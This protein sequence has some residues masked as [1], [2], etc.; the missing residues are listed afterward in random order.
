MSALY[1]VQNNQ[2]TLKQHP[3]QLQA[4]DSKKRIV[5]IL[6]GT[7]G[8][9]T[10][11]LPWWLWREI[12][13]T[14]DPAGNNDY[15]AITASYDL[16]KLKFLPA[17]REV[18]ENIF[19]IG[20]YWSGDR[21][22]ELR[23]PATGEFW[24]K[25]ADDPMWGRIILRSAESGG[26][27]ESATARGAIFDEAGQDSATVD[28]YWAIRR[29]LSLHQGRLCLG[30]TLYNL[31]W[32]KSEIYDPW[33]KMKRQH[34]EIDVIQFESI[35]NPSFPKAEYE[36]AKASLP[37][38]KFDMMY[39]GVY[40]RPAG[41]IYDVFDRSLHT[42][43]PFAIPSEWQ[44]YLGL[45][46]GGVNTA[47]VFLAEEPTSKKLYVY[48]TY[49]EGS[50]T[51]KEHAIELLRGEPMIPFAVGGSP[52]E[53]QWRREFA[54]GGLAVRS[55]DVKEVEIGIDRVYGAFKRG[56][57][58]IFDNLTDLLGELNSYSRDVDAAGNVL[59]R[60]SN[61]SSYH[62]LDALRYIVG[63]LKRGA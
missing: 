37:R 55:P 6:A 43:P 46:F 59:E 62:L 45:D 13:Q 16:F 20:K 44:R 8:G 3:G 14:A 58:V 56:E 61:K 21:I 18:F 38:W 60:I 33:E 12:Q 42:C 50:R 11:W 2:L 47:A 7:Q 5:A 57:I 40:S 9:K 48:R 10:S 53:G 28:T 22:I 17:I 32:L 1:T 4:W 51:G 39:R 41:Q 36:A 19:G 26:G 31:G 52:S 34:D 23:D 30:T 24:A 25:R 29:R 63:R 15:L 49:H 27:L 35:A 54:S